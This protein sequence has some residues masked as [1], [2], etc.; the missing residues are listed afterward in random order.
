MFDLALTEDHS[1]RAVVHRADC[2]EVRQLADAGEPVL[3]MLGC[4]NLPPDDVPRHDCLYTQL[5]LF[6]RNL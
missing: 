1:G 5:D 3:T 6:R 4:T 2:P